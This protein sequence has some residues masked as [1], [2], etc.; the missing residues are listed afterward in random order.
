MKDQYIVDVLSNKTIKDAYL[1]EERINKRFKNEKSF[2]A[3]VHKNKIPFLKEKKI[4]IKGKYSWHENLKEEVAEYSK[5][6]RTIYDYLR[7]FEIF[8][9]RKNLNWFARKHNISLNIASIREP[10]DCF[11]KDID[12]QEFLDY[13]KNHKIE[14]ILEHYNIKDEDKKNFSWYISNSKKIKY[15]TFDAKRNIDLESLHGK[16]Y[17]EIYEENKRWFKDKHSVEL[18]C[19]NNNIYVYKEKGTSKEELEIREFIIEKRGIENL[20][21]NYRKLIPPY[22]VDIF[23]VDLNIAIEYNGSYWHSDIKKDSQYHLFKSNLLKE[24][25]IRLIHIYDYEWINN[26]DNIKEY[27]L[28]QMNMINNRIYARDCKVKE[29]G[30]KECKNLLEYHQQGMTKATKY[31]GLYHN[32]EIVLCMLFGRLNNPKQEKDIDVWEVKREICKKGLIVVGGKSKVFKFFE[33]ENNPKKVVSFVDNSKF[34]GNSYI[35]MGFVLEKVV[36][37]RYD[38]VRKNTLDFVKR[39]PSIY[40]DMKNNNSF[41][42]VYDAGRLKMVKIY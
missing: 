16:T 11:F 33:K 10:Y 20:R 34:T 2:R 19:R 42:K 15:L 18:F 7:K 23:I 36:E 37:A 32:D 12:Y 29:V 40:N 17:D 27:L 5:K 1:D 9:N 30:I 22:E 39:S 8:K 6:E 28:A 26:K 38:W 3:F 24:K 21:F 35:K 4:T 13:C 25:G 41:F 14:E 31:Y